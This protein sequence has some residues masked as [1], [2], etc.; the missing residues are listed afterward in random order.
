[1]SFQSQ[2]LSLSDSD[3]SIENDPQP[4]GYYSSDSADRGQQRSGQLPGHG[5][6]HRADKSAP[7]ALPVGSLSPLKRATPYYGSS[8]SDASSGGEGFSPPAKMCRYDETAQSPTEDLHAE[9][10]GKSVKGMP[11]YND[12]AAKMMAKMGYRKG[13]GLGKN[14]QGRVNIVEASKQRGRRGLGFTIA[15]LDAEDVE[16]DFTKDEIVIDEEVEWLPPCEQPVP[17]LDTLRQWKVI[18]EK[19]LDISDETQYCTEKTL[20]EVLNNKSVFDQL[21][22]EEMRRARTKSNPYETI[23]GVF[24]QNRAA[25]KMAN[26][27]EVLDFMFTNPV[28][29]TGEPLVGRN[30]LLY[31]ADVCAGPGGFSE[32]VLWRTKGKSKGF[33]LTLR[34]SNDFKLEEFLAGPSEMFETHYGVGGA[35]GDGDVFRTDNQ[36]EFAKFVLANT[37]GKGVHMMMAD[38]GFS[39]EG[40][41]NIQEILSK[42][43]YLCQFLVALSILRTGG[44]FVCKLFDLF[45]P[46]SVGLVYLMYRVFDQVSIYKPVTSRPANSERYIVC[47]GCREDRSAVLSYMNEINKDL[48][49]FSLSTSKHDVS[50]VVPADV[51]SIDEEFYNYIFLSNEKIA[52]K[53]VRNLRKIQAFA[54]NPNLHEVRQKETRD[55]CLKKW[56]VPDKVRTTPARESAAEKFRHLMMCSE[57]DAEVLCEPLTPKSLE[58]INSVFD[59]RCMVSCDRKRVFLLGL[60]KG[61]TFQYEL[62]GGKRWRKIEDSDLKARIELPADT[63]LEAEVCQEFR[64][65]A[66]AQR[67]ICTVHVLD[68]YFLCGECIQ[69]LP[70]QERIDRLRLFVKAINKPTK[71]NLCLVKVPDLFK[72][73]EIHNI[74]NR[75]EMKKVK[76][77]HGLERLCFQ[78][79]EG[80]FSHPAG[81][82]IIKFVKDPWFMAFSHSQNRKYFY[83]SMT[84]QSLFEC[85]PDSVASVRD[86][87]QKSFYWAWESGVKVHDSQDEQDHNKVSKEHI[88]SFIVRKIPH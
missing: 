63:L 13:E 68:G 12:F 39:V 20:K 22:P 10:E 82:H 34:K 66:R 74:F 17:D 61:Q 59:Y 79:E 73:E 37:D 27:D 18:G 25:M 45:T 49:K 50:E 77:S 83:N 2:R 81:V 70:F 5:P 64:G 40:S 57:S 75:L 33:G 71:P 15:Q 30:E 80:V 86:C 41:E 60:G 3:A 85:P 4:C 67:K 43:L 26:M 19:K 23:R 72:F 55:A 84:R 58:K 1:M 87:K 36:A 21:H 11:E 42:Q 44:H 53:Q 8:H 9:S 51:I 62:D 88:L 47:K 46:F 6:K 32:Y 52:R 69:N 28:K 16:W 48:N 76:G 31:F 38:G 29:K 54:Q 78:S 24:F 35:E 56:K 14:R 7:K 65:E